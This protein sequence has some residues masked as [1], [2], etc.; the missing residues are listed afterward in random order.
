[1][2][3]ISWVGMLLK[4]NQVFEGEFITEEGTQVTESKINL[5]LMLT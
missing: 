1:M 5:S 4:P 3:F 2:D